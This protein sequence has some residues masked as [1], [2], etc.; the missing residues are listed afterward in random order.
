MSKDPVES[1]RNK[2]NNTINE[3]QLQR[4]LDHETAK[5]LR[6]LEAR[7]LNFYM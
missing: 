5:Y 2:V 3:L 7:T 1:N 4:L 6:T